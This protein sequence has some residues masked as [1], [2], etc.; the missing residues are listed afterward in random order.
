MLI[1][2]EKEIRT[3]IELLRSRLAARGLRGALFTARVDRFYLSGTV[4]EG[5]LW[6]GAEGPPRLF[7]LR[8]INRARS[9]TPVEVIPVSGWRDLWTRARELVG[10]GGIGLTV[11]VLSAAHLRHLGLDDLHAVAD[12]SPDL[13]ALRRRKSPWEIGR[14]EETGRVA[15]DVFRH[16]AEILRPGMTE[17]EF[18][19]LLFAHAM[20]LGH[21]GLL[22]TRG[23][24]EAYSW[25]VLSGPNTARPGAVDTPM[26]GEGLSPAFPWGAGR[27]VIQRGEPV[28]VDF[29]VSLLGYQ[30]DQTRTFCIGPAPD[31]LRDGHDRILEVYR[32]MVAA[33]RH[34]AIAGEVFD[35]G[36]EQAESLG[37]S[38]YLGRPGQRCR[39][40][41]HGVGLEI[42][43]PPLIA[44]GVREAVQLD[45]ALALEPKAILGSHGG[46][47]VEDTLLL[48]ASGVRP[49]ASIPLELIS[50]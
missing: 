16:A 20:K 2:P 18:A 47:G 21:E 31:W 9:E 42:V 22:R 4:Q 6:V 29:G 26:S 46:V 10:I 48:E 41:G 30:T 36:M 5:I 34:G 43:E 3:R 38:G 19:G 33:L 39:F 44:L 27:R 1:V 28:I 40:V 7:V 14:L 50:V 24:F 12:V 11:D 49:L 17:A 35:R 32:S 8:D 37:L 25:H 15:A 13:L 45:S 23:S